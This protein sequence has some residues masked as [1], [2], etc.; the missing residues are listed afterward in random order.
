MSPFG[1]W[2]LGFSCDL[3]FGVWRVHRARL[4]RFKDFRSEIFDIAAYFLAPVRRCR[5][6]EFG[7]WDFLAIW[8]LEF[9]ES[10]EL[11]FRGSKISDRKSLTSPPTFWPRYEDVA[12]WSLVFGIFLRFGIWSLESPSSSPSAVQRFQIGNL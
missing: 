3:G 4:P 11:A 8:D 10:I 1:V 2:C 12:L 9:G 5:P 7:V 6:L